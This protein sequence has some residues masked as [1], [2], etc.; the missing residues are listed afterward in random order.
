[1]PREGSLLEKLKA[2]GVELSGDAL[3][4]VEQTEQ[5]AAKADELEAG[6]VKSARETSAD[7]RIEKLKEV[8][9]SSPGVL[10]KVR[11]YLVSDDGATAAV[12]ELSDDNGNKVGEKGVTLSEAVNDIV[13]ALIASST[14][15][16]QGRLLL[17]EQVPPATDHERPRNDGGDEKPLADRVAAAREALGKKAPGGDS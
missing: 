13:D 9:F 17:S 5:R 11:T 6:A 8:G 1:M 15:D 4:A 3:V 14:K 2:A 12:V 7:Q 16:D 10:K